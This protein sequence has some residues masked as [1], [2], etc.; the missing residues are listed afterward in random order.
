MVLQTAPKVLP[1]TSLVKP[2]SY[3]IRHFSSLFIVT[4]VA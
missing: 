2:P 4:L 3:D 1:N